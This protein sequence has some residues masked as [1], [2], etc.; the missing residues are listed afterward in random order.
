MIFLSDRYAIP[1]SSVRPQKKASAPSRNRRLSGLFRTTWTPCAPGRKPTALAAL[2][3]NDM[4]F[5]LTLPVRRK[6]SWSIPHSSA[7]SFR[8]RSTTPTLL[9]IWPQTFEF[10]TL[11]LSPLQLLPFR[12]AV[13]SPWL[14][15]FCL[16]RW[17]PPVR[18]RLERWACE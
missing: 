10:T 5:D 1:L 11:F 13:Q 17:A 9:S 12:F 6:N 16:P 14:S 2:Y 4:I 3:I 15:F 7:E 18:I 8:H